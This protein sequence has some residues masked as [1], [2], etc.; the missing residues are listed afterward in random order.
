MFPGKPIFSKIG[1]KSH[2]IFDFSSTDANVDSSPPLEPSEPLVT[3]NIPPDDDNIPVSV[4]SYSHCFS[5][6][7]NTSCDSS[8]LMIL[9]PSPKA[10]PMSSLN[11]EDHQCS[12]SEINLNGQRYVNPSL[13]SIDEHVYTESVAVDLE[14]VLMMDESEFQLFK[15]V[16]FR[17]TSPRKMSYFVSNELDQCQLRRPAKLFPPTLPQSVSIPQSPARCP[18]RLSGSATS[19]N[20]HNIQGDAQGSAQ[21]NAQD[22]SQGD[23]STDTFERKKTPILFRN[24]KNNSI[25]ILSDLTSKQKQEEPKGLNLAQYL[26]QHISM[27]NP[28]RFDK[29]VQTPSNHKVLLSTRALTKGKHEWTIEI[30][31]I[32]VDRIEFGVIGTSEIEDISISD[33]GA[34][35]TNALGSRSVYGSELGSGLLY[36]GSINADGRPRCT[37]DLRAHFNRNPS[38]GS[39]ITVR[40]ELNKWRIKFLL[41][42]EPVRYAMS[43]EKN[44]KYFPVICFQGNCKFTKL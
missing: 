39:Q 5:N 11:L 25:A 20:P 12:E 14:K 2:F 42:G 4:P 17:S 8:S 21:G 29:M 34:L 28:I 3:S 43:L 36:Y 10:S 15:I 9:D 27:K 16:S 26:E 22:G 32:D 41:N 35:H 13:M 40:L 18:Q 1:N 31:Q 6:S 38:V 37:R 23:K 30:T 24:I 44:K 19:L 33:N 7:S